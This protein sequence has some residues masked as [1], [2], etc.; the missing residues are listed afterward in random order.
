MN[1]TWE[2]GGH[3][4]EHESELMPKP[5]FR[6]D[7]EAECQATSPKGPVV[8]RIINHGCLVFSEQFYHTLI[9]FYKCN[10]MQHLLLSNTAYVPKND[11]HRCS[12]LP[13]RGL[14]PLIPSHKNKTC[15]EP[16]PPHSRGGPPSRCNRGHGSSSPSRWCP[17]LLSVPTTCKQEQ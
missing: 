1:C 10:I 5:T 8:T 7:H 15:E 3:T 17:Q 2:F 16:A 14:S 11:C 9:F 12:L 6:S 4:K 13:V